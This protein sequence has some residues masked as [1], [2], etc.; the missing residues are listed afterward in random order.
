[1]RR[2][3]I[4]FL[5]EAAINLGSGVFA[6][7]AP[8]AF[9]GQ[10]APRALPPQASSV[11]PLF[12]VMLAVVALIELLLVLDPQRRALIRFLIGFLLGDLLYLLVFY[13]FVETSGFAGW[14]AAARAAV[15]LTLGCIAVRGYYLLN[16]QRVPDT[17]SPAR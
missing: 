1:M 10:F 6:I 8:A 3:Q 7:L 14:T 11:A 15:L 16:P 13:R 4:I 2:F 17:P 5:A 12:G 9:V